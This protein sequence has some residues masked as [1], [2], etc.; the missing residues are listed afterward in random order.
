MSDQFAI[1]ADRLARYFGERAA[2][3]DVSFSL[4]QGQTLTVLGE[5]GAG[6]S[7]LL[8]VLATL[9]RPH[10]GDVEVLGQRLPDEAW[11]VRG[12][13]GLIGHEPLLYRDLTA[14]ENLRFTARLH[15]VEH[16]EIDDLLRRVELT[17]RADDAVR[18]FSR[19]MVQRLAVCRALLSRPQLLL[20]DE[21]L[22]NLDPGAA[23]LLAPLIAATPQRARVVVTHDIDYG[24]AEG[25]W[26]LGLRGGRAEFFGA[27][28][29][30]TP[31]AAKELY[32]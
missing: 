6:K 21:P 9:I 26:V 30:I 2:L 23:D 15:G 31:A 1:R 24:L 20:L 14:R 11:A 27:A 17:T 22:A 3:E 29:E 32:R 5:N 28:G 8:R 7:T 18:T 10:D 13:V 16:D 4:P 19:G 12:R 25:D